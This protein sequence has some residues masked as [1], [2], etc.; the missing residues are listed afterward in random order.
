MMVGYAGEAGLTV[1]HGIKNGLDLQLL[2]L[3][4]K[5]KSSENQNIT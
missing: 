2:D 4:L 5:K 3:I 1:L